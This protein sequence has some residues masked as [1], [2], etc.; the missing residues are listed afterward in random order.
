ML[1]EEFAPRFAPRISLGQSAYRGVLVKAK[2]IARHAV[3]TQQ[4]FGEVYAGARGIVIDVF[5]R[6]RRMRQHLRNARVLREVLEHAR[7]HRIGVC[8]DEGLHA[9]SSSVGDKPPPYKVSE[10]RRNATASIATDARSTERLAQR[11]TNC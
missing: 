1:R 3:E 4:H 10:V 6:E 9:I 7:F 2:A 5:H 8:F 11:H